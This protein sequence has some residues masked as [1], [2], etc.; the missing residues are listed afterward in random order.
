MTN[1]RDYPVLVALRMRIPNPKTVSLTAS[2]WESSERKPYLDPLD[3]LAALT[4]LA[5]LAGA[6]AVTV[7]YHHN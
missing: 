6:P 4:S 1:F 3:V 5:C 2:P 7:P